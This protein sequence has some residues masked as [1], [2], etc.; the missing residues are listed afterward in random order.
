MLSDFVS[1]ERV[2]VRATPLELAV[3]MGLGVGRELG[4]E[5]GPDDEPELLVKGLYA[6]AV[7]WLD[8]E[9]GLWE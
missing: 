3:L 6:S 8:E 5:L 9:G 1:S 4:M 2:P 7:V